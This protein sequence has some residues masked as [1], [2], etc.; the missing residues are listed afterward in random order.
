MASTIAALTTGGGGIATSADSSG[1][2]SLLSGAT[3]VVA[4][5]STGVA[6]TGTLAVSGVTTL[7]GGFTVG[8][9]AAPAFSAYASAGTTLTN[10]TGTK[11]L[12]ATELFDTNSNYSSSRFTPTVEGYYQ[13]NAVVT[14]T[15]AGSASN[16]VSIHKNGSEL[17]R[18][19]RFPSSSAVS[20]GLIANS[21][22]QLNGTTDYIEIYVF[23]N[24]GSVTT[25]AGVGS[26]FSGAMVRSA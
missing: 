26:Q 23:T 20:M 10:S 24:G 15:S 8:A 17:Y 22:V 5:T 21:V 7:T 12:F 16:F 4:V 2:L 25:D 11:I 18:G 1:N 6:V 14:F 3:T 13:I 9:T 19:Q